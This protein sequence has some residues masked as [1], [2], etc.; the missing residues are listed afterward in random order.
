MMNVEVGNET[1]A[2][3]ATDMIDAELNKVQRKDK[4]SKY[5]DVACLLSNPRLKFSLVYDNENKKLLIDIRH[6]KGGKLTKKGVRMGIE[7]FGEVLSIPQLESLILF[8]KNNLK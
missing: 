8:Y 1:S 7:E 6:V 5:S 3:I 4:S 2:K